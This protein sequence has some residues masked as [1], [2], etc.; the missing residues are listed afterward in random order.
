MKKI[1]I[2]LIAIAFFTTSFMNVN[3]IN[4]EEEPTQAT[5]VAV[6]L[7]GLFDG[8][9]LLNPWLS[10]NTYLIDNDGDILHMW[11]SEYTGTLPAYLL[12]NGNLLRTSA[13]NNW[14][15]LFEG[16][17]GGLGGRVEMFD[18]D[19]NLIWNFEYIGDDYCLHN[20][21]EVLP[22]GNI[23]MIVWDN[24]TISEAI[25]AGS[26]PNDNEINENGY[27]LVDYI[28]E[29]EP[30]FPEGGDIV[31]E[32]HAWDHLIQDIDTS[33]NNYGVIADHPELID[34][35]IE[36]RFYDLTHINSVEYIEEFD[37]I[38]LSP[39]H[40]NEIWVIDHSTTTEEAAGH[41]GGNS[42][43]GGD[44]LYRWGNPRN[45]GAGTKND[46]KLYGQ[47]DPRW[48]KDGLPGAGH[49][50]IYNNGFL[51][52]NGKYSEVLEINPP[53]DSNGNYDFKYGSAYAPEEALWVYSTDEF[54]F[55]SQEISGAQRLPNGNTRICCGNYGRLFEVTP[56]KEIVWEYFNPF[57]LPIPFLNSVFK[58]QCYPTD[59][60]GLG[61][62]TYPNNYVVL[63]M[64]NTQA[65]SNPT[66]NLYNQGVITTS[67]I[68]NSLSCL[69]NQIRQEP[70]TTP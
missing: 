7:G 24:K 25:A 68:I 60:P 10:K 42:G 6:N 18:W 70:I 66:V 13:I 64:E 67:T 49:I 41:T 33:K 53:V 34:I 12:E 46:Q 48:I 4:I 3:A 27:M 51:R 28:I 35:N 45:Y 31:W 69:T 39:R 32:W 58:I 19:G 29:V 22:N 56:D 61:D 47:H 30:F 26:D 14:L 20:D 44:L 15:W 40:Y 21:I 63:E 2:S 43:K 55:Y 54:Y 50:T 38:I 37:Q 8:Y 62:F 52:P 65:L 17:H 11:E 59:Y 1:M 16:W 5:A 57:P 23:L 36:G 9:T